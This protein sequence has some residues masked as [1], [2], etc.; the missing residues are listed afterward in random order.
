MS[1]GY[2]SRAPAH[3]VTMREE[4]LLSRILMHQLLFRIVCQVV[5][6]PVLAL[7]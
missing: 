1:R 2:L 7:R 4:L 3:R 5:V 6:V